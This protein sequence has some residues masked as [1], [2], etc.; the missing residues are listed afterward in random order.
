MWKEGIYRVWGA[1]VNVRKEE[2]GMYVYVRDGIGGGIVDGQGRSAIGE[3]DRSTLF[4]AGDAA[5]GF[6]GLQS[7]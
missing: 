1:G 7:K 3:A 6:E 2:W 4:V 5:D